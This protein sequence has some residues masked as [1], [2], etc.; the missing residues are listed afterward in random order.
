MLKLKDQRQPS[1]AYKDMFW[2][3]M[4]ACGKMIG[5]THQNK[6]QVQPWHDNCSTISRSPAGRNSRTWAAARTSEQRS[7]S[8]AIRI[9]VGA[10]DREHVC[11]AAADCKQMSA[12]TNAGPSGRNST[13]CRVRNGGEAN[14]YCAG[15]PL[16]PNAHAHGPLCWGRQRMTDAQNPPPFAVLLYFALLRISTARR[17]I[18]FILKHRHYQ[19]KTICYRVYSALFN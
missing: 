2:T 19:E 9:P 15:S 6:I 10:I 1:N 8:T 5:G 4:V 18:L 13:P 7:Q 14:L 3:L 11:G 16:P 12:E 17:G